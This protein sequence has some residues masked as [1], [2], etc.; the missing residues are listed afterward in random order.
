MVIYWPTPGFKGR[1]FKL[2]V[3]TRWDFDFCVRSSP[4][5]GTYEQRERQWD[6]FTDS[7]E[8]IN[9]KRKNSRYMISKRHADN[10]LFRQFRALR[11]PASKKYCGRKKKV[12]DHQS[13]FLRSV[14]YL[15]MSEEQK[16]RITDGMQ[17]VNVYSVL[18]WY[19]AGTLFFGVTS[20]CKI[21]RNC[22]R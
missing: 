15:Y 20:Q 5:R 2:C 1:T 12:K 16:Q 10:V 14:W 11:G 8:L 19:T 13:T 6:G 4:L 17:Y 9:V 7:H 18:V 21:L 22:D 3:L